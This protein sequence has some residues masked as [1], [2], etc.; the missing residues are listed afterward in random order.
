[1]ELNFKQLT[2]YAKPWNVTLCDIPSN[3]ILYKIGQLTDNQQN[4][5]IFIPTEDFTPDI[6][7]KG[8]DGKACQVGHYTI[9]EWS[10]IYL[11]DITP[12]DEWISEEEKYKN[13][14]VPFLRTCYRYERLVPKYEMCLDENNC[15]SMELVHKCSKLVKAERLYD[16]DYD[17]NFKTICV[18]LTDRYT[19]KDCYCIDDCT[20]AFYKT[21]SDLFSESTKV[22]FSHDS[23]EYDNSF[24]KVINKFKTI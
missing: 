12:L 1:M 20:I 22:T 11:H 7:E 18:Y 14:I 17:D 9:L 5:C 3:A 23:E 13:I 16:I 4:W 8:M 10:F 2:A 19:H 24:E 15:L 6:Y 21:D